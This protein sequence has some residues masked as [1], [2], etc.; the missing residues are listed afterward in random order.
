MTIT[1]SLA[2]PAVVTPPLW[3]L[4]PV[5]VVTAPARLNYAGF[6]L[7]CG[8]RGCRSQECVR[9]HKATHWAVCDACHGRGSNDRGN[10]CVCVN[11]VDQVGPD[12]PGA[13]RPA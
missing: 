7:Y 13:V 12:W 2:A 3:L 8:R 1:A 11:G 10:P 5:D 4:S 9:C 6:C